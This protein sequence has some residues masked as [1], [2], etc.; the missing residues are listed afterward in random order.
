MCNRL[1]FDKI[2]QTSDHC[3]FALHFTSSDKAP[4]TRDS[5]YHVIQDKA[6]MGWTKL[7]KFK[8]TTPVFLINYPAF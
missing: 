2:I 5:N 7:Q 1:A 4:K 3:N 6:K 8:K